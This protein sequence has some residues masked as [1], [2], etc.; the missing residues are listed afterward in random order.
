[1]HLKLVKPLNVNFYPE[2]SRQRGFFNSRQLKV[3]FK[4]TF[5]MV[6]IHMGNLAPARI[7]LDFRQLKVPPNPLELG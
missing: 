2:I 5:I 3:L 4:A 6:K 1:M 7:V